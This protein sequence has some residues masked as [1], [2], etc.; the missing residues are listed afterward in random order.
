M[1]RFAFDEEKILLPARML[2]KFK[3]ISGTTICPRIFQNY[4]VYKNISEVFPPTE[5]PTFTFTF[6]V[7]FGFQLSS[8]AKVAR[9]FELLQT[10]PS[11]PLSRPESGFVSGAQSG[12]LAGSEVPADADADVDATTDALAVSDALSR[13]PARKRNKLFKLKL[14]R[15]VTF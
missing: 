7:R 14:G 13:L 9:W 4:E 5:R 1:K 2:L 15:N 10:T 12:D 3:H 6:A 11:A 8:A